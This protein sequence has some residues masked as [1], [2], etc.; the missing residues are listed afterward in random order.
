MLAYAESTD[1]VHW[2]KPKLGQF[3]FLGPKENNLV[4]GLDR[5]LGRGAHG[6]TIFKDPN[7]TPEQRYKLVHMGREAGESCVSGGVSPDSIH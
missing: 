7:G 6:V 5:A 4:F 1:G 2:T 3:S